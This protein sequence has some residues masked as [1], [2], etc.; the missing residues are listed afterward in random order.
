MEDRTGQRV[1]AYHLVRLL[2]PGTMIDRYLARD[3]SSERQVTLLLLA[4]PTDEPGLL[5]FQRNLPVCKG[6]V[7]PHIAPLLDA[8]VE[9]RTPFVVLD[10]LPTSRQAHSFPLSLPTI[11]R[12]ISQL[13]R[14]FDSAH[15]QGVWHGCVAK[16]F[17]LIKRKHVIA[18]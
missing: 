2:A 4:K 5:R 10:D 11:V 15:R 3:V 6:L 7:H 12:S 13:T 14:A 18:A 16:I 8:G 9:E 17:K 1:A